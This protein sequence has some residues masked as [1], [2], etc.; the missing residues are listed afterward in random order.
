MLNIQISNIWLRN[1]SNTFTKMLQVEKKMKRWKAA[2]KQYFTLK[3][4]NY[5][6][7]FQKLHFPRNLIWQEIFT[8]SRF[9]VQV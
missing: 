9:L 3:P 1:T 7:V 8:R 4:G 5:D 6:R 2:K